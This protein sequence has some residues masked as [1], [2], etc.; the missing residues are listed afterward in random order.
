MVFLGEKE[1]EEL[2]DF[3]EL[4]SN[5]RRVLLSDSVAPLRASLV[6]NGVWL[7]AMPAA[8]LGMQAVKIVGLY[9]RNPERGLPYIRGVVLGF[10]EET[11]DVLFLAD[12]GPVTG[13]RTAAA[14]CLALEL[15]GYR[16]EGP[17]GII[18]AGVQ[19]QYHARCINGVFG[20]DDIIVYDIDRGRAESFA[21]KLRFNV[22]VAGSLEEVLSAS[23]LVVAATTS[24]EP[25]VK[26]SLLARGVYVASIGAPRPVWE[27]DED[28]ML[29]AK[30]LLVDTRE[31]F[32]NESGEALHLPEGVDTIE[33]VEALKDGRCEWGDLK[34]YKS[35]GTALFDLA[36]AVTIREALE[37]RG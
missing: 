8:G 27:L 26:G 22:R 18:G 14:S 28:V 7:G 35:V 10:D 19:S 2:L 30:C 20:A 1:L 37:K 15:M 12:A 32:L 6:H 13:F 9:P 36:A 16:G 5:I 4:I 21:S 33:L 11:G 29:R 24:R 17:V 31:G 23:R 3:K 34:V 25:V